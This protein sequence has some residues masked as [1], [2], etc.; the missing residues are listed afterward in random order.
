MLTPRQWPTHAACVRRELYV[1][2]GQKGNVKLMWRTFCH[3]RVQC[4]LRCGQAP[5]T[6]EHWLDCPGTLQ[7]PLEIFCTTEALPLSTLSTCSAGKSV[8][9]TMTTWCARHQQQQLAAPLCGLRGLLYPIDS[10]FDLG[11]IYTVCFY[12]SLFHQIM[13][14]V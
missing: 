13:V 9:L 1:A 12:I 8:A 10:I 7:A 3:V 2:S 4:Q 14:A 5:R 11:A 6:L